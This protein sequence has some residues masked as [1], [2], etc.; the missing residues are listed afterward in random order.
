MAH[1]LDEKNSTPIGITYPNLILTTST[2]A[3]NLEEVRPAKSRRCASLI[4]TSACG[5]FLAL[6]H[7][8]VLRYSHS[9]RCE[10]WV[11]P[12][13]LEAVDCKIITTVRFNAGADAVLIAGPETLVTASIESS[14]HKLYSTFDV[15]FPTT[16][17][18]RWRVLPIKSV[19]HSSAH[20]Q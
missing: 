11:V 12:I 13:N 8:N 5:D 2:L 4:A 20:K 7:G 9:S 3:A 1:D 6:T 15:G 14:A 16:A 18:A 19:G 10:L 17:R